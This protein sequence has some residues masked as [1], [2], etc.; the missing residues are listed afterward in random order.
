[1]TGRTQVDDSALADSVTT[2][3]SEFLDAA[4][5]QYDVNG[6]GVLDHSEFAELWKVRRPPEMCFH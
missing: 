6:D 4:W 3:T 2:L 5:G 1:M